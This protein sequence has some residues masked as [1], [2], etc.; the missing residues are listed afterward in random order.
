MSNAVVWSKETCGFCLQAI[1]ELERRNYNVTVK[2]IIEPLTPPES[3]DWMYTRED[4]LKVVPNA[5][6]VPQIFIEDKHIGGY[7]ELM[8]FLASP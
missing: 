4:L 2:K 6:S 8:K 3:R 1:K 5:R 7:T